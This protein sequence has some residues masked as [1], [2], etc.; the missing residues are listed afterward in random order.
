[1]IKGSKMHL[2]CLGLQLG[3]HTIIVL[4]SKSTTVDLAPMHGFYGETQK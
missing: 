3:D 2:N 4:I 1:M